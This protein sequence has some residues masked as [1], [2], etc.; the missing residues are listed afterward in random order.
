MIKNLLK[1]T[2]I[3][4]FLGT[5]NGAEYKELHHV[6]GVAEGSEEPLLERAPRVSFCQKFN[7]Y[8]ADKFYKLLKKIPGG[9]SIAAATPVASQ[10][11]VAYMA[12]RDIAD[13]CDVNKILKCIAITGSTLPIQSVALEI[14]SK[15][16]CAKNN[17]LGNQ[18]TGQR[19]FL[20]L[21]YLCASHAHEATILLCTLM[22]AWQWFGISTMMICFYND[23]DTLPSDKDVGFAV[24]GL[25]LPFIW[26]MFFS[27]RP[28]V[29]CIKWLI[30]GI[31]API[32]A[33]TYY[34]YKI[35]KHNLDMNL[36]HRHN[37]K[38][39]SNKEEYNSESFKQILTNLIK[40]ENI[41]VNNGIITIILDYLRKDLSYKDYTFLPF[42]AVNGILS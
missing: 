40:S 16:F 24:S 36:I 39:D 2:V 26:N 10:A 31:A 27:K 12:S 25:M 1:L 4:L 35:I 13:I 20:F 34:P 21:W 15:L 32:T 19:L 18:T 38:V 5:I 33:Y 23:P 9:T 6:V 3:S 11:L 8:I 37:L 42:E 17:S 41:Q 29:G 28:N 14:Y 22:N 30:N 7:K